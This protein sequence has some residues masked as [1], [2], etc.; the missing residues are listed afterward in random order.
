MMTKRKKGE[1]PFD[2]PLL[3]WVDKDLAGEGERSTWRKWLD[4]GLSVLDGGKNR[5]ARLV[6]PK[7]LMARDSGKP[8]PDEARDHRHHRQ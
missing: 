7:E 1:R 3:D 5:I 2:E 4:N 6:M 8:G